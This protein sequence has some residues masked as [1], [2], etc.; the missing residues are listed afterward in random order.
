[1]KNSPSCALCS[2]IANAVESTR[3]EWQGDEEIR[4]D[5]TV[6]C[7]VR[8]QPYPYKTTKDF[9]VINIVTNFPFQ[10]PSYG[11]QLY[12]VAPEKNS[13]ILFGRP[14]NHDGISFPLIRSWIEICSENHS[15]SCQ[16]SMSIKEFSEFLQ[17]SSEILLVD[18]Q[19]NCITQVQE[20]CDYVALSYVWG[21]CKSIQLTR[22]NKEAMTV[23]V[24][25]MSI[26]EDLPQVIR[27]AIEFTKR[28]G[29]RR[30]WIDSLC[31]VQDD[32]AMKANII[33]KMNLIYRYA[34]VTI[35]AATGLDANA[36]LS[37]IRPA[38]HTLVPEMAFI[39]SKLGLIHPSS[40]TS[41]RNSVWASRGW[42]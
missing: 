8:L 4:L 16:L 34:L 18:V 33:G 28:L 10:G 35:I 36:G 7:K 13:R 30:L 5:N 40:H 37:R 21:Q 41:L 42:T 23:P 22:A 14:L 2:L 17:I 39:D 25:L 1:L 9:K 26:L 29:E 27:D 6:I 3:L 12:P 32:E 31:I 15:D 11:M 19:D 38:R 20:P 24:S